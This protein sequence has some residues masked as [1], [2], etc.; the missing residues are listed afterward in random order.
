MIKDESYNQGFRDGWDQVILV[1]LDGIK[2]GQVKSVEKLESTLKTISR[3]NKI[4]E[5]RDIEDS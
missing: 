5:K 1:I 4:I 2:E 3:I